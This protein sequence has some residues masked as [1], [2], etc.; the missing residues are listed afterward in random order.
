[1]QMYHRYDRRAEE[2][3]GWPFV[4]FHGEL[5][6]FIGAQTDGHGEFHPPDLVSSEKAR[7]DVADGVYDVEIYG[8]PAKLFLW[9][10]GPRDF[11][12]T[13]PM[14]EDAPKIESVRLGMALHK[15]IYRT[16]L[17]VSATDARSIA[18]AQGLFAKKAEAI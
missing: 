15:K 9:S 10:C 11:V 16:G 14:A 7:D 3:K 18:Y 2:R 13:N 17:V 4:Y 1:M 8:Q 5:E 12:I 6:T